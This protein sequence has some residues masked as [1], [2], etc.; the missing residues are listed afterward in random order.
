MKHSHKFDHRRKNEQRTQY[1][2]ENLKNW[3][4]PIQFLRPRLSTNMVLINCFGTCHVSKPKDSK[5]LFHRLIEQFPLKWVVPSIQQLGAFPR[6]APH[7][8]R[9]AQ[10]RPREQFEF[11]FIFRCVR[12]LRSMEEL[13]KEV[14]NKKTRA[15]LCLQ[16]SLVQLSKLSCHLCVGKDLSCF[17]IQ[18]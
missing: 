9:S 16:I 3:D 6:V 10:T 4:S 7:W 15:L 2:L 17:Q 13:R 12:I 1:S 14:E 11:P 8:Q 5:F 18:H